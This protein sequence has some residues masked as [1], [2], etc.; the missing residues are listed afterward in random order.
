MPAIIININHNEDG[1]DKDKDDGDDGE[2]TTTMIT[3]RQSTNLSDCESS[4]L[5]HFPFG[6]E[7]SMAGK[8]PVP[9]FK[10]LTLTHIVFIENISPL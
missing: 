8:T 6:T 5:R 10:V 9:V 3:T 2:M 1:D 7:E 4:S